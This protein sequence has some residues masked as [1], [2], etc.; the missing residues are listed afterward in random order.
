MT[1]FLDWTKLKAF[2]DDKLTI[3]KEIISVFHGIEN[4]VE[5]GENAGFQHFLLFQQCLP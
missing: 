1:V 4:I 2:A 5:K 3:A